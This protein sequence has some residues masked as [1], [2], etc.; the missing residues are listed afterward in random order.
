MYNNNNNNKMTSIVLIDNCIVQKLGNSGISITPIRLYQKLNKVKLELDDMP[1]VYTGSRK[2]DA[3]LMLNLL[4]G[5]V[6]FDSL[7]IN[8]PLPSNILK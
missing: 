8:Y 1:F 6:S 5:I 3:K 7:P 4:D 2:E